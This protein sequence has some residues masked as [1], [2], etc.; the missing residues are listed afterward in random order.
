MRRARASSVV[1]ELTFSAYVVD[2]TAR[3]VLRRLSHL[4]RH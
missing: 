1:G 3:F 4:E 2:E